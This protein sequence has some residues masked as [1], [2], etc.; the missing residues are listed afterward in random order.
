MTKRNN[1][2]NKVFKKI[3]LI[4]VREFKRFDR[5]CDGTDWVSEEIS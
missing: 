5:L 3:F 2:R 1:K 4:L